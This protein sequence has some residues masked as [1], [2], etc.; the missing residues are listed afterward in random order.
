MSMMSERSRGP[1]DCESCNLDL[2]RSCL[3]VRLS[4]LIFVEISCVPTGRSVGH[5]VLYSP[6]SLLTNEFR[7]PFHRLWFL[8][9]MNVEAALNERVYLTA[10]PNDMKMNEHAAFYGHFDTS[11]ARTNITRVSAT[12]NSIAH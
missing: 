10:N 1:D 5:A 11:S 6:E 7:L 12:N 8:P 2:T 3:P 4:V 9:V